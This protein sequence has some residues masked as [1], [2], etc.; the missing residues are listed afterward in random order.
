MG[1]VVL[2]VL[3]YC[4]KRG[5]EVRLEKEAKEATAAATL[6]DTEKDVEKDAEVAAASSGTEGDLQ[7]GSK[8]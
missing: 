4:H 7:G 3:W 5:R 8:L 1:I 2:L 6:A